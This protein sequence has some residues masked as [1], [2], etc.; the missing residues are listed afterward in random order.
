MS[1]NFFFKN[2][3]MAKKQKHTLWQIQETENWGK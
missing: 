3:H 1:L 2:C